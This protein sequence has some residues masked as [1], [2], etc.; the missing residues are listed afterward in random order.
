MSAG[1]TPAGGGTAPSTTFQ[2]PAAYDPAAAPAPADGHHNAGAG[3]MITAC[4]ATTIPFVF[5]GTV[6]KADGTTGAANV[7]VGISDGT[8]TLT[9]YSGANGNI[10]LP[11]SAAASVNWASAVIALR[12][13]NGERTK[14]ASA[15]RGSGCNGNGCHGAA[16]RVIEP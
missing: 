9:A 4:H 16:M 7:Q 2:W 1:G 13:K 10:W 3:C 14:P 11:S 12:N 6:Y 15:G 5:G 8:I